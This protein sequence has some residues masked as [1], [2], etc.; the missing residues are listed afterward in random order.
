LAHWYIKNDHGASLFWHSYLVYRVQNETE[1][2]R[3]LDI[4]RIAENVCSETSTNLVA[5]IEAL[6]WPA[7]Q[8]GTDPCDNSGGKPPNKELNLLC[9]AAYLNLIPMAKRLLQEGHCPTNY[10]YI[11]SSRPIQLAALAGNTQMLTLF[12]EH[13]PEFE[14]VGQSQLSDNW[15]AKVGPGSTI[16]AA[17]RGNMDIVRLAVYP[18]SR[19]MPDSTDFVGQPFGEVDR[20]SDTGM[21]LNRAQLATRNLEVYKYIDNF[22]EQRI[23]ESRALAVHARLG[24]L[25]MVQYLLDAGADTCGVNTRA[26]NPLA[27][28]CRGCHEEVV[29]L[30]LDRGA[31]PDFNGGV[32]RMQ[33]NA[34]IAMAAAAGSLEIF[35]KILSKITRSP[36]VDY[37]AVYWAVRVEHTAMVQLLLETGA[38]VKYFGEPIL[39]MALSQ[40]LESMVEI[41]QREGVTLSG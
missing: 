39:K 11:F 37:S 1:M 22:F 38:D 3:F 35:R 33:G 26:G 36:E 30:L 10:S 18:P 13:L 21:D 17:M 28:A 6:C 40:G 31:D 15:R 12:Q 8:R 5:T 29:D 24:N 20:R 41:L 9:A 34:P 4:R 19:A 32:V 16:G 27:E 7:L 23:P 14:V 25:E 2:H